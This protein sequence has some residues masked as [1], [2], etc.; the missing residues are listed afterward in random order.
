MNTLRR[1]LLSLPRF[2]VRPYTTTNNETPVPH[3]KSPPQNLRNTQPQARHEAHEGT[4]ALNV[5]YNP[6]GGGPAGIPGGGGFSFTN[7]PILDAMLTTA[8]GLG[9]GKSICTHIWLFWLN[10]V[11]HSVYW[12]RRIRQMV[13]DKCPE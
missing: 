6:P 4:T 11:Y 5:P 2:R 7:S 9:A 13:Q 3:N 1:R 12:R 8:I 10:I